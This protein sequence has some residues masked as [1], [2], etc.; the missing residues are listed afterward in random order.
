MAVR[1]QHQYHPMFTGLGTM[2][3]LQPP[4]ASP[5]CAAPESDVGGSFLLSRTFWHEGGSVCFV[6]FCKIRVYL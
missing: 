1:V 5:A 6:S 4:R 3:R 2:V